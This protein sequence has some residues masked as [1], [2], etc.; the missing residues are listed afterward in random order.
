M[1]AD[2]YQCGGT[3]YTDMPVSPWDVMEAVLTPD[4]FRGFLKGC[5]IK[6]SMRAGRKQDSDEDASKARHCIQKLEEVTL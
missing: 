2:D 4:E 6:Y 1:K 3:H 5:V